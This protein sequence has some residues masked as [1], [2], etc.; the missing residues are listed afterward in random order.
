LF[1]HFDNY[2]ITLILPLVLNQSKTE[3]IVTTTIFPIIATAALGQILPA[4]F[5]LLK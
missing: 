4:S 1:S 2:L 5:V 3:I